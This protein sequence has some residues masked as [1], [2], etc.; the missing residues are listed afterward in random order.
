MRDKFNTSHG[1]RKEGRR[2]LPPWNLKIIAKRGCFLDFEWEKNKFHQEAF[3]PLEFENYSKK[4]L[5]S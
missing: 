5:F 4:R 1:R 3:A 2:P